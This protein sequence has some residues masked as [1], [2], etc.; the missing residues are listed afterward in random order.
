MKQA[1]GID[2]G[3]TNS[4]AAFMDGDTPRVI[5][6]RGGATTIPS[7]FAINDKGQPLVG[8]EAK[9]QVQLNP[10]HTV[11][12]AKRLI[13]REF[14]SKTIDEI[15]QV[16]TYDMVAGEQSEVL[17]KVRDQVFTLEQIS[18]A[19]LKRIKEVAEA[20]IE[21]R[22]DS[23][24]ITVPAYFSDRQRQAVRSAGKLA[25]LDIMRILN[26]PTAA[27]LAYGLG[28][29]LQQRI[30]VYDL[31]GGTFDISV[32]D[33]NDQTFEV[34]ATGGDTFLGGVDFDEL[35]MK[36]LLE[37][38]LD[39][40]GIDLALDKVA[41]QRVKDAAESAKIELS[42]VTN[43]RIH[44]PY[45]A[46]GKSG[47][48]LDIEMDLSREQLETICEPL[49]DRTIDT[50][51]RIFDEA[52]A[53][54]DQIDEILLVGGQS[55]MPLVKA[56]LEDYTGFAPCAD[57]NPYE[58]VSIGA[59]IMAGAL[60][61]AGDD[62]SMTLMDVLPMPI[63]IN[64]ADGTMH[65][66]FPKNQPLPKTKTKTLTTSKDN[67]ESLRLRI[68]QGESRTCTKNE[69]LGTFVFSNIRKAP[70]G[71]VKI[72]ISFQIDSEG[73]L[74]LTGED[75]GSGQKVVTTM[76]LDGGP[77][78]TTTGAG[79][80]ESVPKRK[81][82]SGTAAAREAAAMR[83]ARRKAKKAASDEVAA[84]GKSKGKGKHKGK[85]KGKNRA[86]VL[87]QKN[88]AATSIPQ[89]PAKKVAAPVRGAP[90]KEQTGFFSKLFGWLFS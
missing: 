56:K 58:A 6:Q 53:N 2:L 72:K 80:K 50:C 71:D 20:G 90:K 4:C 46:K 78:P 5:S 7:V 9:Q 55:Q 68:Y 59:A 16:F 48:N 41:V 86:K 36:H 65:V 57:I 54:V 69:L 30:A 28:R 38:F 19:I 79:R 64:K 3:T 10:Q 44:I 51:K 87:G 67:Q 82:L 43:T 37:S 45:I 12:S 24:V 14:H 17:V 81:K 39:K 66:L 60:Q 77:T 21:Q 63:G 33:I 11:T 29:G 74:N 70:K 27:A 49:V 61:D 31:G 32:I 52:G 22:V 8:Q 83:K 89:G 25:G 34:L 62:M 13:G 76:R 73:I 88:S 26:E 40:H 84:K 35:L 47:R 75:T 23:A 1:I 85:N 15:R 18:A 42:T